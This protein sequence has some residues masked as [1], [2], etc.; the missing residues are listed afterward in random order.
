MDK[1][2]TFEYFNDALKKKPGVRIKTLLLEQS[3]ISGLGNIY[4]DEVCFSAGVRPNRRVK[5]LKLAEKQRLFKQIKKVLLKAIKYR[6]TS[7]SDYVGSDGKE[8]GFKKLLSVYGRASQP[9]KVCK[10]GIIKKLKS[11]A[12]ARVFV[13]FAKNKNCH[14]EER[15][16]VYFESLSMTRNRVSKRTI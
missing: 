10:R 3:L 2:F 12:E 9:C 7:F 1:N 13:R 11:M 8:G 16:L 4:S 15:F 14:I 5:A 6:G